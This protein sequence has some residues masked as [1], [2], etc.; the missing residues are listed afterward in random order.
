VRSCSGGAESPRNWEGK[1][2][3]LFSMSG[4]G[5]L[6]SVLG[7]GRRKGERYQKTEGENGLRH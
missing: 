3:L 7:R 4:G 5:F 1:A 2:I 6:A